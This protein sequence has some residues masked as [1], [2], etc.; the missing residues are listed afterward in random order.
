M[1]VAVLVL[2]VV[3]LHFA[4]GIAVDDSNLSIS[5]GCANLRCISGYKCVMVETDDCVGCPTFPRCVQK[6]CDTS[7][8]LPCRFPYRCVLIATDCCPTATCRRL[9]FIYTI[10]PPDFTIDPPRATAIVK[11]GDPVMQIP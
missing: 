6:E 4:V 11:P 1:F 9:P 8:V 5:I 10:P 2:G 3:L 7:C